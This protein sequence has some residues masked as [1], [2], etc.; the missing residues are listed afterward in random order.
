M[1]S[2]DKIVQLKT[3]S[4]AP[5]I[6][7]ALIARQDSSLGPGNPVE[8]I[9][10]I[11]DRPDAEGFIPSLNPHS[12]FRLIKEA[13]FDQGV[14]LVP[15]ASPEQLQVI[16][17]LDCWEGDHLV[18]KRMATWM[19]VLVA[20]SDDHHLKKVI[21]E[22]DPEVIS[23]FFK[24]HILA[25]EVLD[26][27]EGIPDHLPDNVE[28]SPDNAYALV[29]TDDED[30][31]ALMRATV[32]RLYEVDPAMAWTLFEAVRWELTSQ[33]E[34]MALQ[35]RTSRLEEF[36]YV[37]RTEALD[38]YA[39]LNPVRF[40]ERWDKG[41]LQAKV[42]L[43][44]PE[45]L[46]VPQVLVDN[47]D[48]R[49]FFFKIVDQL[50]DEALMERIAAELTA[51]NNRTMIA[52]GIEPGEIETGREVVRRT[53]GYLSLGLEFVS[54]SDTDRAGRALHSVPL[55]QLF[56]VGY[57]LTRNLQLK[58]AQLAQRPT[59]TLVEELPY[60]LLNP[61][62][63]ALFEGLNAVRPTYAADRDTF[64]IFHTQPQIDQAALR[65]GMLA[66][67]QLWL[68]GVTRHRVEDLAALLYNDKIANEPDEVSFDA[69]FAT[70]LATH[71]LTGETWVRGLHEDE[72]RLLPQRLRERPWGDDPIGYFEPVIGPILVELPP[73]TSGLA[74][75]WLR[76]MLALLESELAPV[77]DFIGI[78][79][80][81]GLV[82]VAAT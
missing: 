45:S 51:L 30:I 81:T 53:G 6:A 9:Q 54:R 41:E 8:Q 32:K 36:G 79:P 74:T 7:R 49:L 40:R 65:I 76:D 61:D 22:L 42:H 21:R 52:D 75:R 55:R 78:A 73:A 39:Y 27:D 26:P 77:T 47:L 20:E 63:E 10:A 19:A 82:L 34:E 5:A 43:T 66:F 70:A 3:P 4:S 18:G 29:Y 1:S 62:E 33:M 46:E 56:Q 69:F 50:D 14:D 35:W 2:D 58:A 57:S 68:F 11:L 28:L 72:L 80:Y 24:E 59:L 31:A 48:E 12:L 64:D 17:D 67:K 25:V 13:G 37:A 71:L 16:I 15:Y 38:V 60:S 44:P 23:L